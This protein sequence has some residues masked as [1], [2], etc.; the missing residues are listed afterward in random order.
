[1]ASIQVRNVTKQFGPNVVLEN[2]SLEIRTGETVGLVG[3]NGAGK[4]TLFRLIMGQIEPDL[5]TV[6]R[7]RGLQVGLLAQEPR[8][9]SAR[10]LHDE[11][12]SVFEDLLSME[13]GLLD[14]SHEMA[15]AHDQDRLPALMDQYDRLNAR[16]EAAGGH[17]FQARLNEILGGLGFSQNEY[18]KPVSTLSGGQKCRAGLAK[19]LL[20]D[21]RLL[22]LDEPTNHLDIDATR[23]LEKYLAG[24]R[25]GAVIVSHDRY[26]LD[27]LAT[28]IVEVADRQVASYPGNYSNYVQVKQLRLVTQQR[29]YEKDRRFIEKERAFIAK[30]ISGQRTREARGRRTRLERR[31]AEGEF[32][33]E[34]ARSEGSTSFDF[35]GGPMDAGVEVL[36]CTNLAKSFGDQQLFADLNLR[37]MPGDRVGITGANGTGKT[38]LLRIALGQVPADAGTAE[39]SSR[40]EVGYYDQEHSDLIG[41]TTVLDYVGA[42]RPDLDQ[43]SLRSFLGRFRFRGEDAFKPVDR[44]SGGEQ[45]R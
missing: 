24:H 6:T 21:H 29:Q 15:D 16:F 41:G 3:P 23:W 18:S 20:E 31:L 8:L 28:R 43:T 10:T 12:A 34:T 17:G 27:K 36:T 14:L 35:S 7:S 40:F 9:D 11:V 30:H 44:L 26:L 39:L 38:T 5:G 42:A 4:T 19:L 22:L 13:R 1:M 33:L 45:S 37:V 32:V 25:G 2:V